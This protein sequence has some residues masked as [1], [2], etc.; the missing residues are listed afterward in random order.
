[1]YV[2]NDWPAVTKLGSCGFEVIQNLGPPMSSGNPLCSATADSKLLICI[3]KDC[4]TFD[5]DTLEVETVG[6]LND[7]HYEGKM[8]LEPVS[9]KNLVIGGTHSL[10]A[11]N[12]AE[13]YNFETGQWEFVSTPA[14]KSFPLNYRRFSTASGFTQ[15]NPGTYSFSGFG[16]DDSGNTYFPVLQYCFNSETNE[17]TGIDSTHDLYP[18]SDIGLNQIFEPKRFDSIG[19]DGYIVHHRTQECTNSSMR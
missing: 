5:P 19:G 15:S 11:S 12:A 10:V 3:G 13:R 4:S 1:M 9:K 16:V 8:I 2:V 6:S 17:V 14:D 18:I 7:F